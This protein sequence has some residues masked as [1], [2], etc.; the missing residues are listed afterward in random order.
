MKKILAVLLL[1]SP[2]LLH[3]AGAEEGDPVVAKLREALRNTMLQ[4]RDVQGQLANA[5]AA[6]I[7]SDA[8]VKELTAQNDKLT[9]QMIE[10]KNASTNSIAE[11][12]TRLEEQ[13]V[14]IQKLNATV[15]QWKRGYNEA[16]A[17]A[18]KKEA[19]RAKAAAQIIKL[20]RIVADQQIKNVQMYKVGTEILDR[21]EKFGLG[22]AILAR[23]PFVG[24]T[25]AKF[26][27]LMQDYQDKLVDQRIS[28]TSSSTTSPTSSSHES[29][30]H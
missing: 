16:T 5:Q 9:R 20:D 29:S 2:A 21:Y 25:R 24:M 27:T 19:E 17:L 28:S 14:V 13:G 23:E 8:K 18:Q 15:D 11:L 6:Q 3:A 10:D 26:Q 1:L 22:E 4:M 12:N 30:N 7:A